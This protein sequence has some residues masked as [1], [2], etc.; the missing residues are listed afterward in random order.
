[1]KN[2]ILAGLTICCLSNVKG[3]E[4]LEF[5][6]S[7]LGTYREFSVQAERVGAFDVYDHFH[8]TRLDDNPG[9]LNYWSINGNGAGYSPW[10]AGNATVVDS[11]GFAATATIQ[12]NGS[13]L[14]EA[15]GWDKGEQL[16]LFVNGYNEPTNTDETYMLDD[17]I[18]NSQYWGLYTRPDGATEEFDGVFHDNSLYLNGGSL[19][20][21]YGN[22]AAVPEPS[23]LALLGV[24]GIGMLMRRRKRK[25]DQEVEPEAP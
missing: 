13:V 18:A 21:G 3:A 14:V 2:I 8:I 20:A 22:P 15:S 10:I 7:A 17:M 12:S 25:K 9:D 4:I 5:D 6:T 23:S 16:S 1:M 19:H 11:T 24:G